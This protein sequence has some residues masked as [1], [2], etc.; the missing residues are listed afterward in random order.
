MSISRIMKWITGIFE[1][2]LAIPVIGGLFVISNGYTPLMVMLILHI[3]TLFL[4]K[5]DDGPLAGSIIGIV[6]SCLAWI[7]IV[8]FILHIITAFVLI[9]TALVPDEKTRKNSSY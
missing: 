5:R 8:G 9:I 4:S 2:C 7:P 1:A 6:T 3:I